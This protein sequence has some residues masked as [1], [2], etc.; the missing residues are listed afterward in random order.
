MAGSAGGGCCRGWRGSAQRN[1]PGRQHHGSGQLRTSR[2][3]PGVGPVLPHAKCLA[4]S[5]AA[6]HSSRLSCIVSSRNRPSGV[7]IPI[8]FPPSL[9]LSFAGTTLWEPGPPRD[10]KLCLPMHPIR[11][12]YVI[13]SLPSPF[14]LSNLEK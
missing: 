9:S 12:A 2:S 11:N 13:V 3:A 5:G 14:W 1:A 10:V 6:R 7:I 8:F 4:L